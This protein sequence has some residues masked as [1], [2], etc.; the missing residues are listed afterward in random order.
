MPPLRSRTV[1]HGRNMAGARALEQLLAVRVRRDHRTVA[2]QREAQRFRQAVHRV[3]RE[4]A[5][6]GA[7]GRARRFLELG[8][9]LVRHRG[10]RRGDHRVDEVEPGDV[11]GLP[12]GPDDAGLHRAAGHEH[13]GDVQPERGHQH[14]RSDLVTVG[15]AHQGVGAVGVDHVLDRVGD[16]FAARQGVQHAAVAHGDAV[17]DR[18][19][20]ELAGHRTGLVHGVGHDLPYL[21]QVHV[22]GH[23]LGEAVGDRDDRLAEILAGNSGG[24]Q[25]R[26][27][28][29]HVPSV[30]H[31]A[32]SQRRHLPLQAAEAFSVPGLMVL[33]GFVGCGWR[34]ASRRRY[35]SQS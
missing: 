31:G 19:R 10:I 6:A 30:R 27:G 20:V 21:A 16:Q 18:D 7:A 3:G 23:E 1:T 15:D 33:A 26:P 5:R 2:R 24:A 12:V 4:H 28:T 14:A 29:G 34:N 22:P 17:V 9:P 25:Q 8:E 11:G 32:G 35:G 13:G